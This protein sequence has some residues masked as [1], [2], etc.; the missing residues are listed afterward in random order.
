MAQVKF[1]RADVETELFGFIELL[2]EVQSDGVERWAFTLS[3]L[4]TRTAMLDNPM[5]WYEYHCEREFEK[6][7]FSSRE[8]AMRYAFGWLRRN[9]PNVEA[10]TVRLLRQG[11][12]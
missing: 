10:E 8:S 9:M 12:Y 2:S 11:H 4:G 6:Y 1:T 3:Q 7:R 5:S